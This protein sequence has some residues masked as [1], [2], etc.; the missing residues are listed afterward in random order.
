[1]IPKNF[2]YPRDLDQIKTSARSAAQDCVLLDRWET[3]KIPG[4]TTETHRSL[5]MTCTSGFVPADLQ[6]H[7]ARQKGVKLII[8]HSGSG[9]YDALKHAL[10]E[11][12]DAGI[13]NHLVFCPDSGDDPTEFVQFAFSNSN[14]VHSWKPRDHTVSLPYANV[15]P[16]PGKPLW[17]VLGSPE[18]LLGLLHTYG[19]DTVRRWRVMADNKRVEQ[20]GRSLQYRYSKPE[21][22]P[23]GCLEEICKMVE[24]GG[25][26]DMSQVKRN[27][28]RAFLVVY[29]S[30]FGVIVGNSSLKHP[31]EEYVQSLLENTGLDFS[32]YLERGYTSVRPE[33]R[34]LGVGTKLLEGLTR[35]STGKKI[36]SII[37]EDNSATQKIAIRNK[38]RKLATFFSKKTGKQVGVW[39]PE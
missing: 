7:I 33:Y 8:W 18:A 14:I 31:R 5:A 19:I 16:L 12:A 17:M 11:T 39:V 21:N 34:G 37:T 10:W 22:L 1:V 15:K 35:R 36:Y 25:S 29:A 30:E 28:E 20:L 6:L 26:V 32:G 13:W 38:T 24:A 3:G 27:L 9:N 23:P 4:R 2:S